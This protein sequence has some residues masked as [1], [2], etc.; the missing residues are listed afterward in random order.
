[1]IKAAIICLLVGAAGVASMLGYRLRGPRMIITFIFVCLLYLASIA[2]FGIG[3][4]QMRE[5][6]AD[7][8]KCECCGREIEGED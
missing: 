2:M 1:M 3:L 8:V 6:T 4:N 5:E 7:Q